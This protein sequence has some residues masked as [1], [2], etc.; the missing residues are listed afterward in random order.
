MKYLLITLLQVLAFYEAKASEI[1]LL[2]GT[3]SAPSSQYMYAVAG[4]ELSSPEVAGAALTLSYLER[5]AIEHQTFKHQDRFANLRLR[6]HYVSNKTTKISGQIG[7][8]AVDGYIEKQGTAVDKRTYNLQ[9][10]SIKLSAGHVFK[11]GYKLAISQETI[12]AFGT[13]EQK[14]AYVAWPFQFYLLSFGIN[15]L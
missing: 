4:L 14:E 2:T 15:I 5:P 8:G 6:F 12:I 11:G 7:Y 1:D 3:Y 10:P 9:G 13:D